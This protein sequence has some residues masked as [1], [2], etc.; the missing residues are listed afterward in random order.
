MVDRES[1]KTLLEGAVVNVVFQKKDMSMRSMD[2]TLQP[3]LLPAQVDL[4]EA[5]SKKE[6]N[7]ETL[8][9]WDTIA[10]GWRSFRL[11]SVKTI[12]GEPV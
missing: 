2:C 1:L 3:H 7:L 5:I 9:V 12:A 8:V 4:E 11:D 6:P 10:E